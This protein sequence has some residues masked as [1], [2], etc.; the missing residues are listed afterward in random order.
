MAIYYI[1]WHNNKWNI[2]IKHL[3]I[4][5]YNTTYNIELCF[6]LKYVKNE[7]LLEIN[8]QRG[9]NVINSDI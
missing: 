8:S 6:Q 3:S 9:Q 1:G 4:Y 5:Y 7:N 2:I